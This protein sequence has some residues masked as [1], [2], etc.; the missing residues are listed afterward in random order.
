VLRVTLEKVERE[1][2]AEADRIVK[3]QSAANSFTPKGE[4]EVE[5][6]NPADI[7]PAGDT[8]PFLE[9]EVETEPEQGDIPSYRLSIATAAT[10]ISLSQL[11]FPPPP[12]RG[13]SQFEPAS[14]S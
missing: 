7:R 2:V 1:R 9:Y 14:S 6:V 13:T 10:V 5:T 8:G 12:S 11:S 4:S 3:A